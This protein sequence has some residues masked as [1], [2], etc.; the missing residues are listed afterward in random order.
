LNDNQNFPNL[1]L[2]LPKHLMHYFQSKLMPLL[3]FHSKLKEWRL[4][5][6][7]FIKLLLFIT[8]KGYI[9]WYSAS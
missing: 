6:L 9:N 7:F 4:M 3:E 8:S 5:H 1:P 2:R